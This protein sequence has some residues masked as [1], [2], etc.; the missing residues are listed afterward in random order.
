MFILKTLTRMHS[1][2]VP[3]RKCALL[4]RCQTP[5]AVYSQF[6]VRFSDIWPCGGVFIEVRNML[7]VSWRVESCLLTVQTF[8]YTVCVTDT[9]ECATNGS[10]AYCSLCLKGNVGA[11]LR[12]GHTRGGLF[13]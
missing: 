5:F 4:S 7:F 10:H 13:V 12:A 2:L 11:R 3:G 9:G 8:F 1:S 6:K